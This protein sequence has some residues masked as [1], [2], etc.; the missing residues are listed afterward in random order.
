[1]R[2]VSAECDEPA[3]VLLTRFTDLSGVRA[4]VHTVKDVD[5]LVDACRRHFDV[6]EENSVDKD[7]RIEST[8]FGYRSKHLVLN[9]ADG[10]APPSIPTPVRV[11]LQIRTFAQHVWAELYHDIGYKSEFSIPGN[12]TRDFARISAMLEECDKGF[13]GIFD[14]L[15][16]IESHLDQYLDTSRLAPLARQLEVLHQV[17]PENLRVVHRLVRVHNALGLHERAAQLEPSLEGRTDARPALKRDLGFGITRLEN[18][19]PLSPEF[20]RGQELIRSAVEEDPGDV[21][22]LSTLAGTYRKQGDRCLARHFYH[23]AHT[24]DPGF[25][26]ALANFLLEELLEQD[27][28]GIVE[29]FAAGINHARARCL[30]QV[31]SGI[32]MPWVYFDL[33]FYELLQGTTIPSLNL[34]ARGAAAAS[35]DW[36]IETTI[37]SLSD[38]L[39][40]QPGHAGLQSAIQTLG[41]TLAARFPG[42]AAPAALA[43]SPSARESLRCDRS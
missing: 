16:C 41:L 15:Q 5:R 33:A 27:D 14:E 17:E 29:H 36:M 7:A 11:E 24:R 19:S 8:S 42:K 39:E 34:Y 28:F 6:D 23:R 43:S 1:M 35:A 31:E 22:A 21:D 3:D 37:G 30:R 18:R 25:S 13:Q 32:N 9:V 40:R 4:I 12:W 38:L 10:E 2:K 20:K 26:Y